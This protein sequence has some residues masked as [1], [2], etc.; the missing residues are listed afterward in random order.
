[1][2]LYKLYQD[3]FLNLFLVS[4]VT[5]PVLCSGSFSADNYIAIWQVFGDEITFTVSAKTNGWIGIGFSPDNL[6]VCKL[7]Y[8]MFQTIYYIIYII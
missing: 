1:M 5:V 3:H 6:M 4:T 7:S 8:I 2:C